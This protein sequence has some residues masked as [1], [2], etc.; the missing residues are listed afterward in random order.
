MKLGVPWSVTGLRPETRKTPKDA[1]RRSGMSLGKWLT[2]A[3]S[4]QTEQD[5]MQTQ[6]RADVEDSHGDD[7]ATLNERLD[8]LALRVKQ[9]T[10]PGPEA[11]APRH[12]RLG[13]PSGQ[14]AES[15]ESPVAPSAMPR[16]Q[17]PPSL[18]RALSEITARKRLL[19]GARTAPNPAAAAARPVPA[20][21]NPPA[22]PPAAAPVPMQ[23][24][25]G[26][27]DQLRNITGQI[28][29]LRRPGVEKA[30]SALREELAE[31]GRM[32]N[33]A[34]PRHAIET[35]EKRIQD[36]TQR[37]AEGRQAGVDTGALARVERGLAEVRDALHGL[38]PAENLVGFNEA[39][40]G[41]AHKIDL[42]VAQKDPETFAQLEN[43]IT[44]LRGM[45]GHIASNETVSRLAAEVQTLGEKI[46]QFAAATGNGGTLNNL[47]H[48]MATL[49][50]ALAERSQDAGAVP[51]RLE[52][53]VELLAEKI[54]Q[55]QNTRGNDVAFRHLEDRIVSL[56]EKLDASDSRLGHL[57]AI[58]RGL[59]DILVSI[60]DIK[61]NRG[62]LHADTLPGAD[63]LKHD[64]SR[65]HDALEGVHATLSL[66]VDRLATIEQN[67]RSQARPG[68][69]ADA[70]ALRHAVG[71][72]DRSFEEAT[73]VPMADDQ[74][75][76][77]GSGA[78][79]RGSAARMAPSQG[80]LGS[81]QAAPTPGSKSSFIAAARRAA[82]A[83]G[84]E[85]SSRGPR[86]EPNAV[87]GRSSLIA[88]AM[89]WVKSLFVAASVIA[90]VI[91]AVQI[92]GHVLDRDHATTPK[93]KTASITE[94]GAT[95][96]PGAEPS[97]PLNVAAEPAEPLE[98]KAAEPSSPPADEIAVTP[99]QNPTDAATG[100]PSLLGPSLLE[101]KNDVTG[102]ISRAPGQAAPSTRE[103]L[104]ASGDLPVAIGGDRL[105]S[106]AASGD[107]AAAY[108]VG[109]RFAEGHGVPV[110]LVEAAQWFERAADKGLA[111]AQFRYASL[112]EK[113]QGVKKD[114]PHARR[115]YL[116]AAAKG[117]AK[118]MHNLAVLYAEGIDG[119]PDYASAAEWF[120]KA[121]NAGVSDSQFNLGVLAARGLGMEKN[122]AE[123][124]KWFA[125]AAAHGDKDAAKKRDSIAGELDAQ[126]L[127][128]AKHEFA[129]FVAKPEPEQA[130]KVP[131]PPGGW[132]R[133]ANAAP[134][135]AKL[136]PGGPM[137]LGAFTIGKQ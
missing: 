4:Q 28:E 42:I 123:S 75:L 91:G 14:L 59:A 133:A 30:I 119:K 94:G 55:L 102:S 15:P 52:S 121:A 113:G 66:V 84:Q 130:V 1:A 82:Q 74:P 21:A 126:T 107:A 87:G 112:L 63:D 58:E 45:T 128:A 20:P 81:A 7:F 25:A 57:E 23:N 101:P 12:D 65:T 31:I 46:E 103:A 132:D 38:T 13:E 97:A 125:L 5:D 33:E 98:P 11:Y 43:A 122:L 124:Y 18:E 68:F 117:N 62:N 6:R 2:S 131:T 120:R 85:S 77:P 116:A 60:D 40:T 109:A 72:A 78:P 37:A 54:E 83:A 96:A 26:L 89:K 48:R 64:I 92:V 105:R 61:A 16:V 100:L 29:T 135:T 17:L 86:A 110:N 9:L 35:I 134:P 118:A 47:E 93:A 19:K 79:Y 137:A 88:K 50:D 27:E 49:T 56:M 69:D 104:Q 70:A 99:Q 51:S 115:L 71:N 111:P 53:L 41:L 136:P 10:Q 67:I 36:L 73:T 127:A 95:P 114:L 32:L 80:D 44:T 90:I 8:D 76:E 3:I 24:L 39:V 108:E 34:L 129:T 22:P 106:A